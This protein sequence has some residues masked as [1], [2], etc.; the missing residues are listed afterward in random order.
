VSGLSRWRQRAA[1]V[2]LAAGLAGCGVLSPPPSPIPTPLDRTVDV[3]P[4]K[5]PRGVISYIS[6]RGSPVYGGSVE[7]PVELRTSQDLR[8]LRGAPDDFK[9]FMA[10]QLVARAVE[11]DARLAALHRTVLT[12]GC[13]FKVEI[14][15]WGIADQV[16][17]GRERACA[18][19]SNDVI[20]A[21]QNGTWR[22]ASRMQGGWDCSELEHYR[23]PADITAAVCWYGDRGKTRAYDGPRG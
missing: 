21:K 1:A 5:T 19:E 3:D 13:D 2:V 14:R 11:V 7:D 10:G 8:K 23:V 9:S 20:W 22:R 6:R 17:T 16:A 4:A 12:E 18:F 15:V